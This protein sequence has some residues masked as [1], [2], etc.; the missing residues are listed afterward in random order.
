MVTK[1]Y[2]VKIVQDNEKHILNTKNTLMKNYIKLLCVVALSLLMFSCEKGRKED[3]G[4][5]S[6]DSDAPE[7]VGGNNELNDQRNQNDETGD[8]KGDDYGDLY[9]LARN[10]DGVPYMGSLVI[11][12]EH[13]DETVWYPFVMAYGV[14]GD[15][16]SSSSSIDGLVAVEGVPYLVFDV[17]AEGEIQSVS[18][19]APKEVEFGKINLIRSPNSVLSN[20]LAEAISTL[21]NLGEGDYITADASGRLVAIHGL[22]DWIDGVDEEDDNTIDSPRENMAIYRELMQS[23]FDGELSFLTAYFGESDI[24]QLAASAYAAGSDKTGTVL[25][26]EIVYA[27]GFMEAYNLE[28]AILLT[29]VYPECDDSYYMNLLFCNLKDF[30]YSRQLEYANKLVRI[31][32][33]NAGGTYVVQDKSILDAITFTTEENNSKINYHYNLDGFTMACDDAVQVLEFIH[34]SDLVEYL[35]ED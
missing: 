1:I 20:G 6:D 17:N 18:N 15:P 32:T 4:P 12:D 19:Y 26:D 11:S 13:G 29:D 31:T 25:K 9:V 10:T 8:V 33:L 5:E 24:L 14:D 3:V 2:Q 35:G 30:V 34:E 23:G 16:V 7:W 21:T 22:E 27:N 28:D